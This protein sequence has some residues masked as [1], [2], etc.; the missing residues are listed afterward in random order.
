MLLRRLPLTLPWLAWLGL[1]AA[2]TS[3]QAPAT[4][5]GP[6]RAATYA[7]H[8]R[9]S[10]RLADG[11][12]LRVGPFRMRSASLAPLTARGE[13]YFAFEGSFEDDRPDGPWRL[14]FGDLQPAGEVVY[15]G[16]RLVIDVAGTL[17][18][19]AGG[20]RMGMLGDE[21]T[22]VVRTAGRAPDTLFMSVLP[23]EAGVPT[24]SFRVEGGGRSLLG[25]LLPGGVAHDVW[26]V[27]DDDDALEPAEAWRFDEG[28]LVYVVQ[29]RGEQ[30]DTLPV[31]PERLRNP[32]T[33]DLDAAYL[34][35]L[36][37]RRAAAVPGDTTSRVGPLL[38]QNA[39]Y[40]RTVSTA[41]AALGVPNTA[42]HFRVQV[43]HRPLTPVATAQLDTAARF[44]A[45]LTAIN[46]R[47]LTDTRF[48]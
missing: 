2:P 17:H 22:H 23:F 42:P 8:A 46:D 34:R 47:L 13:P 16:G 36:A 14:Q 30:L 18:E 28:R 40:Y 31:Y 38:T 3:G 26:E 6:Y 45:Q 4:Y 15:D 21:W 44:L 48:K 43:E 10:Y 1:V 5:E 39:E 12:T 7:G 9:F 32:K 19:A 35:W 29:R 25:R 41:L 11:D 33:I 20:L 24:K 27:F 37:L